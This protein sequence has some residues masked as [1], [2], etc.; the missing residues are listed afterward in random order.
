MKAVTPLPRRFTAAIL[1]SLALH[2]ML[3]L[4]PLQRG[5]AGTRVVSP[6][7]IRLLPELRSLPGVATPVREDERT[8]A[9]AVRRSTV[10]GTAA[11]TAGTGDPVTVPSGVEGIAASARSAPPRV[12]LDAARAAARRFERES[13]PPQPPGAPPALAATPLE[14]AVARA[15]RTQETV[16]SRDAAGWIV[17]RGDTRCRIASAEW[18]PFME[19]VATVPLCEAG[20]R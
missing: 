3:A 17:R 20:R 16:E 18:R 4:A 15:A 7:E 19:G 5:G 10:G 13:R 9:T 14:A 12:D 1:A 2:A 8:G 11:A 6:L